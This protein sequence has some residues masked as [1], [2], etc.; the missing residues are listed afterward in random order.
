MICPWNT[1]KTER[2]RVYTAAR[3]NVI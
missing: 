3:E 2:V 1:V